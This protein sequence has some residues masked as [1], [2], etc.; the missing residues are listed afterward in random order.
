MA[1]QSPAP[2]WAYSAVEAIAEALFQS[3]VANKGGGAADGCFAD[4]DPDHLAELLMQHVPQEPAATEPRAISSG[5]RR[6]QEPKPATSGLR[7]APRP[8]SMPQN[9]QPLGPVIRKLVEAKAQRVRVLAA[10]LNASPE[11]IELA[12]NSRDSGLEIRAGGWVGVKK[13]Q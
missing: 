12:I 4:A 6:K 8:H 9:D 7:H 13:G 2:A 11:T 3:V 5:L 1:S 10:K